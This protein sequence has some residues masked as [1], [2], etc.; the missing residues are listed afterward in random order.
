[1]TQY[2]FY[3]SYLE[4]SV[5]S[6]F[7]ENVETSK[8]FVFILFV[9]FL[10]QKQWYEIIIIKSHSCFLTRYH[11]R[12]DWT[13]FEIISSVSHVETKSH[14]TERSNSTIKNSFATGYVN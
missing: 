8:G 1:M 5:Y 12:H 9:N 14:H 4:A 10:N 11:V 2:R 7:D 13:Q 3:F 6:Q